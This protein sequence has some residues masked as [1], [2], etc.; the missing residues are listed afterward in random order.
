M[1]SSSCH[2]GI[3][4]LV[5]LTKIDKCD[6]DV[7]GKDLKKTFLSGRLLSLIEVSR[8]LLK[9]KNLIQLATMSLC[10]GPVGKLV[11][12]PACCVS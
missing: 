1:P 5:F 8:C 2:A 11:G 7:I 6:P 10:P 12:L 9:C 3:P 4:T